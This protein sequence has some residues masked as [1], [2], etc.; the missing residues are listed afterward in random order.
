MSAA[1]RAAIAAAGVPCGHGI[2]F[3]PGGCIVPTLARALARCRG[4]GRVYCV[5]SRRGAL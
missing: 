5:C 3:G 2:C 1:T 4:C